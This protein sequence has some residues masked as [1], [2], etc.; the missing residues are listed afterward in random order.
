MIERLRL[1]NFKSFADVTIPFGPLTLLV[2]ANAAGK[3]NIADALRFLK[4]VGLGYRFSDIVSERFGRSGVVEW[5]G[6]RGGMRE[7]PRFGQHKVQ[8]ECRIP[9][10]GVPGESVTHAITLDFS[11]ER[12]GPQLVS[13]TL[14]GHRPD[15]DENIEIVDIDWRVGWDDL[16]YR[17][18]KGSVD[19]AAVVQPAA[20]RLSIDEQEMTDSYIAVLQSI[21]FLDLDPRAMRRESHI[22]NTVLGDHG[23]NLSSVLN[24]LCEDPQRRAILLDWL[25][26]LT[27][28]DVTDFAFEE[29]FG[30]KV[31]VF[32]VEANGNRTSADSASDGTLRFLAM[33]AALL[34][35]DS[36]RV[37]VFEDLDAGMHPSRL[38]LLLDLIERAC[39][40]HGVQV[41]ATTHNPLLLGYLSDEARQSALLVHRSPERGD[42]QVVRIMDL[43]DIE[44]V[45]GNE[46]TLGDLMMSGWIDDIAYFTAAE[47]ASEA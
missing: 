39:K 14:S 38:H 46:K 40:S 13:E 32:L 28:L 37:Y 19:R 8:F 4:G 7:V 3:S 47:D 34:S 1:V 44:R 33:V 31:M 26:A 43:P 9:A 6:I 36:G 41:I 16:G 45:L 29:A 21:R 15:G 11:D 10:A 18:Y 24:A 12:N 2:G 35:A 30:G 20:R 22:S 17:E 42:S 23:E 25:Q 5:H 27:P